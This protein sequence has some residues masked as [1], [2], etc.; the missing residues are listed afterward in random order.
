MKVFRDGQRFVP[1]RSR[2]YR[3]GD[4]DFGYLHLDDD[5]RYKYKEYSTVFGPIFGNKST[6]YRV[7]NDGIRGAVRRLS[8]AREPERP[9]LHEIL[10]INQ[11]SNFRSPSLLLY[12]D[13]FRDSL[14]RLWVP[15]ESEER[16]AEWA[17][18]PHE[19]RSERLQSAKSVCDAG[20]SGHPV[21]T[22]K[23]KY[24]C[25]PKEKLAPNSY[26]RAIG[27][28]GTPAAL[29]TAYLIDSA[30]NVFAKE[31]V[32]RH[33]SFEY[34]KTPELSKLRSVFTAIW[35][36][37]DGFKL[38]YFSDD[39]ILAYMSTTGMCYFDID[40]SKCD[41]SHTEASLYFV[42]EMLEVHDSTSDDLRALREMLHLPY[43]ICSPNDRSINIK[44]RPNMATM[45]SGIPTTVINNNIFHVRA[46][47]GI[48][49][50]LGRR[51]TATQFQALVEDVYLEIGLLI[52]LKR[53][54]VFQKLQF[55]KHSPC[56]NDAGVLDAVLNLGVWMRGFG[57]C[58]GD[59]PGRGPLEARAALRNSEIVRSKVHTGNHFFHDCMRAHVITARAAYMH[60]P[61][62][63]EKICTG[64]QLGYIPTEELCL[65]YDL[66]TDELEEL[67]LLV[68]G[69]KVGEHI[70]HPAID[71][72]M[73]CDYGY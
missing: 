7:N 5:P 68:G 18:A 19:K 15:Q 56:F 9:F 17:D 63:M 33:G 34:V 20:Q 21:Y 53:H 6:M 46:A 31:Y 48:S 57:T 62:Y 26:L 10:F 65:R 50:R 64:E 59:L 11:R 44:L 73:L 58:Y 40:V 25:K 13:W 1:V 55:L 8:C 47:L 23:V 66:G 72:I 14:A 30:K 38:Y 52:K 60:Q 22:R 61:T 45:P 43:V 37:S 51:L 27:D 39:A 41:S 32:C 24:V 69:A 35:E 28:L 42:L 67:S 16:R 71:R 4:V 54:S 3:L 29:R 12:R 70:A 36:M 49:D 2:F